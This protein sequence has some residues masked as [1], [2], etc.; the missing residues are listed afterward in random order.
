MLAASSSKQVY[1]ASLSSQN[2][3][4]NKN[5]LRKMTVDVRSNNPQR[6]EVLSLV[7][8][9]QR[10]PA[11][12]ANSHLGKPEKKTFRKTKKIWTSRSQNSHFFPQFGG[13]KWFTIKCFNHCFSI[14]N[15]CVICLSAW[16]DLYL[17]MRCLKHTLKETLSHNTRWLTLIHRDLPPS[18]S[19]S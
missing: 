4:K 10:R 7:V 19:G 6:F 3:I 15:K 2:N 11:M 18:N 1:I 13:D 5:W 14:T 9:Q 8:S 12:K 17:M 16:C